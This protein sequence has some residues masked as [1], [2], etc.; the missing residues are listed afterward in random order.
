MAVFV[1]NALPGVEKRS[2]VGE[3]KRSSLVLR[4]PLAIIGD[5]VSFV[6][7]VRDRP[8]PVGVNV[9]GRNQKVAASHG[10]RGSAEPTG[11]TSGGAL[12]KSWRA[13]K[14]APPATRPRATASR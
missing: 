9:F 4:I 2:K 5:E 11:T 14:H 6:V 3:Q 10:T 1:W 8:W 12:S 13:K 7:I